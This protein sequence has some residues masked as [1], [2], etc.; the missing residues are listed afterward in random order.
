MAV[1]TESLNPEVVVMESAEDGAR[2][3]ASGPLGRALQGVLLTREA[4]SLPATSLQPDNLASVDLRASAANFAFMA[5]PWACGLSMRQQDSRFLTPLPWKKH[6]FVPKSAPQSPTIH[7]EASHILVPE[8]RL[9]RRNS[10]SS[11]GFSARATSR[12]SPMWPGAAFSSW[13]FCSSACWRMNSAT[14]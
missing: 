11:P 13:C 10:R 3:Y 7:C 12:A 8:D 2:L 14:S 1:C 6:R 4:S 9:H 5:R